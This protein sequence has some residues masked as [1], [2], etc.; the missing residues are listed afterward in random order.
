MVNGLFHAN[1]YLSASN[2]SNEVA[3]S[4]I[5]KILPNTA[6]GKGRIHIRFYHF[7]ISCVSRNIQSRTIQSQLGIRVFWSNENEIMGQFINLSK[8]TSFIF[9]CKVGGKRDE[10]HLVD[11]YNNRTCL[12]I[13]ILDLKFHVSVIALALRTLPT[14]QA[15][16]LCGINRWTN[17]GK[18]YHRQT[19][20]Q[21]QIRNITQGRGDNRICVSVKIQ[22]LVA[23]SINPFQSTAGLRT[24]STCAISPGLWLIKFYTQTTRNL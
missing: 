13:I 6:Y 11:I 24:F 23:T 1:L 10:P 7:N 2:L 21:Q 15:I 19:P 20:Y 18:F 8:S 4:K 22:K 9:V 17:A 5:V 3:S 14:E 16:L 12:C